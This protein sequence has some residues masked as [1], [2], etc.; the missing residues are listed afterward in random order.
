MM[1]LLMKWWQLSGPQN[2]P[3]QVKI[4]S[5]CIAWKPDQSDQNHDQNHDERKKQDVTP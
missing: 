5:N 4:V 1:L 3:S 2:P